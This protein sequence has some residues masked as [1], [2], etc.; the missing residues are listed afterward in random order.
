MNGY[1]DQEIRKQQKPGY[2]DDAFSSE[3][4]RTADSEEPAGDSS[5]DFTVK[6]AD[7]A[8]QAAASDTHPDAE[9]LSEKDRPTA[10]SADSTRSSGFGSTDGYDAG[11]FDTAVPPFPESNDTAW[12]RT[13]SY[14]SPR[15]GSTE[16][17]AYYASESGESA[18][19]E[20]GYTDYTMYPESG[21]G[22]GNGENGEYAFAAG[23]PSSS[24]P[25]RKGK[26]PPLQITRKAF[27]LILILCMLVTFALS[28]GAMM[29]YSNYT[30]GGDN[31]A[32]DYKL[33]E[34]KTTLTYDSI[35]KKTQNS[36]VS[37]TTESVSTDNWAQN[38]VTKGAGSGVIIQSNGYILTCN[39]VIDGA[40]K[41]TVTLNN[42][43]T[44][45]ASVVGTDSDNDIA[46]IKIKATDL[47][48]ATYG[49]SSKLDVGD[50]VVAIGNPLGELSNTATTGI[51]SALNRNLTIDGKQLNLL[52]TDAS[53]NPGNSGGALFDTSGNLVGIVVAKS[54]GSDVE[55]LGFAIPVNRAAKIAS[56]LIKTGKSSGS[57][58]SSSTPAIGVT[59]TELDEDAAA[60]YNQSAGVYIYSVN[61][62]SAKQAGLRSG[63]RIVAIG[64]ST[65]SGSD[66]LASAL[67]KY[68]VGEKVKI[69][70]DR[71]GTIKTVTVKLVPKSSIK[72]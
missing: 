36:V 12:Q 59:V 19:Y 2:G 10:K 9:K 38:Y 60:Q 55:G 71:S 16:Q 29:L 69:T 7:G 41:I 15:T 33:T 6:Q 46:V 44:Y 65:I 53:I 23:G 66:D 62:R 50:S 14:G 22:G 13:R 48:A 37:I 56:Q 18:N 47:S 52:Q 4:G 57:S 26:K 40:T 68:K 30:N 70:I 61:S 67:S 3:P 58:V 11:S 43:K 39:H 17:N 42:K 51:I 45:K 27:V 20:S 24:G 21:N 1:D 8:T 31:S 5:P 34:S 54:S 64:S 35:I 28:T 63:D 25:G 49:N 32:T 72:N